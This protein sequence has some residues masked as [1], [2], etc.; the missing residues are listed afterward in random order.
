MQS[1]FKDEELAFVKLFSDYTACE[2]YSLGCFKC[3]LANFK[4]KEKRI[5]EVNFSVSFTSLPLYL[6]FLMSGA[7]V[8][9]K[10][11]FVMVSR[12]FR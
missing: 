10:Q 8:T 2:I 9:V 5:C 6:T 12:H 4:L 7:G 11:S 3:S 1:S